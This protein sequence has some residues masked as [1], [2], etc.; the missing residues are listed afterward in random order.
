MKRN[1]L[2]TILF[3]II[4]AVVAQNNSIEFDGTD[5]YVNCGNIPAGGSNSYTCSVWVYADNPANAIGWQGIVYHGLSGESQANMGL[6]LTGYLTGGTGN[7]NT[8]NWETHVTSYQM[9]TA[10]WVFLTMV[11]D[12]NAE[13][14]SFYAN[15]TFIESFSHS[16]VPNSTADPLTIGLGSGGEYFDGKVDEV[17]IWNSALTET[18]IRQN[19]YRELPDPAGEINLLAYYKCN[20][21]YSSTLTDTKGSYNGTLV[22]MTGEE[23]ATSPAIFGPKNC[24]DF[25]G[26]DDWISTTV[27]MPSVYTKEAWVYIPSANNKDNNII[28]GDPSNGTHAFWI[29]LGYGYKLS[30]GHNGVWNAVQDPNQIPF[31]SWQH[32]AVTYASGTMTLYRNGIQVDQAIGV[33]AF[34]GTAVNIGSFG[35]C[36]NLLGGKLDEVR[37]W[38]DVRSE[39]EIRQNMYRNLNGNEDNLVAYYSFDNYS[40]TVLQDFS[41]NG[42]DGTLQNMDGSSDWIASSAFTTWLNTSSTAWSTNSNWS[43]GAKPTSNDNVGIYS[44]SGGS[45]PSFTNGDAAAVGNIVVDMSSDWL[46]GGTFSVSGNLI[47]ESDL[48][49]NGQTI[50]LGSTGYLIEDAGLLHGSSGSIT[51]TRSLSNIN[52]NVAGLGAEITTSADMGSTT[53]SRSHNANSSPAS[54]ERRYSISPA[55]NSGLNATLIFH[56]NNSEMNGLTES[57][58]ELYRSTDEGSNWTNM[59]GSVNTFVNTITLTGV[60]GFSLWTAMESAEVNPPI[61]NTNDPLHDFV[62][63]SNAITIAPTT[64]VTTTSNIEN[65]TVSIAP[66]VT[67]DILSVDATTL[68]ANG[69]SSSWNNDT[70]ILRISGTG[71]AANY[72]AVLQTVT[73]ET[74]AT[75]NGTRTIDFILGDGVGLMIGGQQHF[76]EV[77]D[78]GSVIYWNNARSAALASRFGNA[79]GYLATITSEEENNYLAEK[80]TDNTWIGASDAETEDVWKWMD[81]PETGIQF[82]QGDQ[83]GSAVNGRYENWYNGEPNDAGYNEDCAHMYGSESGAPGYWNDFANNQLVRYYIVEYGG[84]GS[85]FTTIDD[86]TVNVQGYFTWDGSASTNWSTAA[87]WNYDAVPTQYCNITIPD[88][89]ND[90]IIGTSDQITCNNLTVNSGGLLTIQSNESGTGSLIVLGTATGNVNA[91]RYLT[92]SKWHYISEPVNTDGNF[93]ELSLG[94][95]PGIG[96]DQF[97]RWEESL[98]WNSQTGTW[99]DILNGPDGNNSTMGSEGFVSCKGYSISFNNTNTTLN[100]EGVP[101]TTSQSISL[102][103]TNESSYAGSNLIGNPFCSSIA[104]NSNADAESNFINQN[105]ASLD[106]TYQ[107]VYIWNEGGEWSGGNADYDTYNNASSAFYAAPGQAFMVMV[108]YNGAN[109]NFNTSIRKHSNTD[110]YKNSNNNPLLKLM[111]TGEKLYNSTEIAFIPGM[112]NGHDRSYDAGKLKGNPDISLYTRLVE[113]NG[114]N[115]AIQALNNINIDSYIIPVGVDISEETLLEFSLLQ[116]NFEQNI[117]LEDRLLNTSVN[118]SSQNYSAYINESGTGR[119]FIHFAPVGIMETHYNQPIHAYSDGSN[120]TILNNDNLNGM[121][122]VVNIM[123]QEVTSFRLD[124]SDNSTYS[125][126]IPCGIYIVYIETNNGNIY[127]DKIIIQ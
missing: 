100:L 43:G 89:A 26:V 48:N 50:D 13:S 83:Y 103:K 72:Q 59:N 21:I 12:R 67:E 127:S 41:G 57:Y 51:T 116:T 119:F 123:G 81:G 28:S 107:A 23:F 18:E 99:V 126:D 96:N 114:I 49:L 117:Y 118:L 70:K 122:R 38:N 27:A 78:N 113:D 20:E 47:L 112:T 22:N 24:L 58:L 76:Y 111:V 86:A 10:A 79:Q 91:Q 121:V 95:T 74:T 15:G 84:D 64:T 63:G 108:A 46:I 14:I 30:A 73:F 35:V 37:I 85:T 33:A 3:L 69:L 87:N 31:G 1:L 68:T 80:V 71:S 56:Y 25:D 90:P 2:I 104:I 92:Q 53:I 4:G 110:F 39:T 61:I 120:I 29:S 77:I 45:T 105:F 36:S 62:T 98:E 42:N 115:Y 54:I 40:G 32:I 52:E 17:R 109:I 55:N 65:A 101:Y 66:I 9:P 106:A 60:D 94:L 125:F 75:S 88:V 5:D 8:G 102:T 44:Y 6:N 93:D 34:T 16:A 7:S 19:M 82:W 11:I 124:N 97:Y